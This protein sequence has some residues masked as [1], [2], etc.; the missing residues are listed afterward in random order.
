VPAR[1]ARAVLAHPE[2][3][4]R[5]LG[6]NEPRWADGRRLHPAMQLLAALATRM[7][8]DDAPR[9]PEAA[10]QDM[11]RLTSIGSPVRT[12]VHAFDRRIP[13]PGGELPLRIYRSHQAAGTA[14]GVVF[15][16]GGG[17]VVGDL[18]THD[19]TCRLLADITACTVVAVDYRLA[20]EHPFPAAIDD[21]V[22]AYRWVRRHAADLGI[23]PAAIGILGDS[24][25][26]T[27]TAAVCLEARRLGLPR[28][29]AQGLVYPLTD[30]RM[31][32]GSYETFAEDFSLTRRGIEWFRDQYVPAGTDLTDPRVSPLCAED[33]SG[34][35][36]AVI[37]TAGFDP[38]RD[39]GRA[40]ADALRE[41]GVDVAYRCYDD[42]LHG[43]HGMML[44]PDAA[45]AA[46]AIDRA[47]GRLLWRAHR[48]AGGERHR[49]HRPG[50]S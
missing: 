2:P 1:V 3:L 22:A 14:P 34:L 49:D 28:P 15:A 30:I 41:A 31:R 38:L 48:D 5:R 32:F 40:Y 18:D 29:A 26:A 37:A 44:I 50:R 10:R 16:H 9:E 27:I 17:F 33:L 43:F 46:V 19:P 4:L 45:A 20:P 42:F 24:A 21:T 11:R 47:F 8:D 25:G 13:G 6:E 12:S 39:D 7:E 23:D 35:P 36:P